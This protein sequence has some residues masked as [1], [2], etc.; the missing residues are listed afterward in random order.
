MNFFISLIFFSVFSCQSIISKQDALAYES[1]IKA[2]AEENC[3]TLF[4]SNNTESDHFHD[5]I[6]GD[7]KFFEI[8]EITLQHHIHPYSLFKNS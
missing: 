7:K 3:K 8:L 4:D 1:K 5:I 2:I 6:S